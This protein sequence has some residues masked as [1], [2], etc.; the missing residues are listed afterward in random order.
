MANITVRILKSLLVSGLML[1]NGTGIAVGEDAQIT[2]QALDGR[3][4]RPLMNRRLLVFVGGSEEEVRLE[5]RHFEL[6]SDKA[7][8]AHLTV[9]P[10][11]ILWLQAWPDWYILC[12][13]TPNHNTF[14]V[15]EILSN[16]QVAPNTCGAAAQKPVPGR[17]TLFARP[18]HFWERMRQ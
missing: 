1:V 16:G 17:F 10:P 12:Q 8:I 7:G 6:V 11:K 9:S 5:T 2:V 15:A 4:G 18:A 13:H 14:S 3:N